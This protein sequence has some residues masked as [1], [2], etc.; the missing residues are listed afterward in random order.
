MQSHVHDDDPFIGRWS[1][2][3]VEC[4]PERGCRWQ[5]APQVKIAGGQQRLTYRN[6]CEPRAPAPFWDCDLDWIARRE[7]QPVQPGCS[8]PRECRPRGKPSQYR[9]EDHLPA[10][11]QASP[12]VLAEADASP[13]CATE[14]SRCDT[15]L[16]GFGERDRTCRERRRNDRAPSHGRNGADGSKGE[17]L[18]PSSENLVRVSRE[19]PIAGR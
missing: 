7:V 5:S 13:A 12:R 19:G 1:T 3:Q 14:L 15:R 8:A 16:L 9:S 6:A 11:N 17:Q 2:T 18:P 4:R 10:S